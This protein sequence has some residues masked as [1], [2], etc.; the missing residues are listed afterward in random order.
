MAALIHCTALRCIQYNFYLQCTSRDFSSLQ[1]LSNRWIN[2]ERMAVHCFESGSIGLLLVHPLRPPTPP[3]SLGHWG[4]LS[5][6][7]LGNLLVV[8]DVQPNTSFLSAVYVMYSVQAEHSR[9]FTLRPLSARQCIFRLTS[10]QASF[11][12]ISPASRCCKYY[13][14][15]FQISATNLMQL[16]KLI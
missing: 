2:D 3:E 7:I 11:Q 1:I 6:W 14:A 10:P 9:N 15:Y 5:P 12:L 4:F 16:S 13:Q 8:G